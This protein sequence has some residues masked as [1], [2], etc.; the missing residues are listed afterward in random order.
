MATMIRR[1]MWIAVLAGTCA[2]CSSSPE[3]RNLAQITA[4]NAS[5]VN[6]ELA[7]FS[8]NTRRIA[9]RRAE[10][11]AELSEEVE[12]QQAEFEI[13]LEGARATASIAGE[14]RKPNFAILIEELQRVAEAVRARQEAAQG[15]R[16]AVRQEILASQ[17]ALN[18][19]KQSLA[20]ISK[21]LGVLAKEPSREEQ[22]TFLR[23]FLQQVVTEVREARQSAEIAGRSAE[24]G[25]S[26]ANN[27][28]NEP[29]E[30]ATN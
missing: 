30:G 9:D 28:A 8:S 22:L 2:A 12:F 7:S 13:F 21:N 23:N 20:T 17:S 26:S 4:S 15:R 14:T 6:T 16:A 25:A 18:F 3:V 19:P 24:A 5:I 29:I 1:A 27:V 11:A 10:A